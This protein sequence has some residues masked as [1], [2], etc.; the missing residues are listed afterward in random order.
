MIQIKTLRIFIYPDFNP[1]FTN[2]FQ[3]P[4]FLSTYILDVDF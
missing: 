2:I 4:A 1:N 3:K